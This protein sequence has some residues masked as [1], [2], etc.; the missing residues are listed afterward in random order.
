MPQV[1]NFRELNLITLYRWL[2]SSLML[3]SLL[4]VSCCCFQRCFPTKTIQS[5]FMRVTP[6]VQQNRLDLATL[7]IILGREQRVAC[8]ANTYDFLNVSL[9][10]AKRRS[11]R[12]KIACYTYNPWNGWKLLQRKRVACATTIHT[13]SK[14]NINSVHPTTSKSTWGPSFRNKNEKL[15]MP[16]LL[17][18]LPCDIYEHVIIS[19]YVFQFHDTRMH[20]RVILPNKRQSAGIRHKDVCIVQT[21]VLK[22]ITYETG[23]WP[24]LCDTR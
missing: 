21:M 17:R 16:S 6:Q 1:T 5:S 10:I 19:L 2:R 7:M 4:F 24:H 11:G 3:C 23:I 12:I 9:Y 18:M 22:Q 15:I 14:H 20:A 8:T 13:A